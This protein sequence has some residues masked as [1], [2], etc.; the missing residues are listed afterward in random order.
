MKTAAP[1][2]GE[3]PENEAKTGGVKKYESGL[4]LD[5]MTERAVRDTETMIVGE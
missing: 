2:C 5:E 3:A 4:R 1:F